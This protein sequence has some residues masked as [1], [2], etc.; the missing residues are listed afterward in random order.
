VAPLRTRRRRGVLDEDSPD[1]S[2]E[3]R[4][5]QLPASCSFAFFNFV[6]HS[7]HSMTPEPAITG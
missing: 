1:P 7:H 4:F 2:L 3:A 5:K 6:V